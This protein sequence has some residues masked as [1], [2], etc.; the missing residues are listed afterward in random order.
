MVLMNKKNRSITIELESCD[1]EQLVNMQAALIDLIGGYRFE[2]FGTG[3]GET[4]SSALD[5]L[6][7][8]LPSLEQQKKAF[9]SESK[10]LEPAKN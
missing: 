7:A 1:V 3:A 8:I 6:T 2:D 10:L 5:L 4:V 9:A